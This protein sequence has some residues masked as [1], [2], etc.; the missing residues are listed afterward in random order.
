[1]ISEFV[2][3]LDPNGLKVSFPHPCENTQSIFVLLD[4]YHMLKLAR[5][6]LGEYGLLVD[7]EGQKIR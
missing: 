3:K 4:I 6:T 7:N 2:A 1:M 5:N